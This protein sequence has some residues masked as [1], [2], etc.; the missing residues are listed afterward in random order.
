ME[1]NDVYNAS[2]VPTISVVGAGSPFHNVNSLIEHLRKGMC[3]I[4]VPSIENLHSFLSGYAYAK[5]NCGSPND[6]EY[7]SKFNLWVR[8]RY[9]ITS[10]QGWSQIIRFFSTD[11]QEGISLFWR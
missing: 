7:L 2:N 1:S 4:G 6:L 5:A 9:R 3:V 8:D 11:E 10:D